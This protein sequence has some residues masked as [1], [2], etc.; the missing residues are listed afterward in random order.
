MSYACTVVHRG[1]ALAEASLDQI[2]CLAASRHLLLRDGGN[3]R[4]AMTETLTRTP[5]RGPT[6]PAPA[7]SAVQAGV[8]ASTWAVGAGLV[9]VMLPVLLV[10]AADARSGA[11]AA[12]ALRAAGQVWLVAHG[13]GLR[14]PGGSVGLVPLGLLALPLLLLLRAGGHSARECRVARLPDA[15]RLAA[16]LAVPYGVLTAVVSGLSRTDAVQP[17]SWQALLGGAV[18]GGLGGLA[19]ILRAARLWPAVLPA[20][21]ARARRLLVSS[22]AA[23]GVVLGTGALLAGGSLALHLGRAQDLAAATS[24]G[25]TG[26]LALLL[27]GL[28]LVPNAAIWGAAWLA[29]PGFAVGVG[30]VVGPFGHSLG[31]VPAVPL[32]AAL[33]GPVPVWVGLIALG[34]PL[35]AGALAG[36]LVARALPTTTWLQAAREAALT[37]PCAGA[38]LALACWASGGPLGGGRLTDV[39]PRPWLIGLVLAAEVAV[40]AAATAI[41]GVRR[42]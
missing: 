7:R 18:V 17:V 31:A 16:A 11:S 23:L 40:A 1:Q 12:E 19:G 36:A 37:G 14:V 13:V 41:L 2:A 35:G 6:P 10:W 20:L 15:L 29:G 39:G 34:V 22:A 8:T 3:T 4:G 30:T 21:P 9:A 5:R 25:L 27:L 32:L 26:G 38:L 42:R 33:P 24:P 28:T